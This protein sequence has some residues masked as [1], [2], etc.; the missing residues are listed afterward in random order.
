MKTTLKSKFIKYVMGGLFIT[1]LT[2]FIPNSSEALQTLRLLGAN[3]PSHVCHF[4]LLPRLTTVKRYGCT[5]YEG[6]KLE[7][8]QRVNR[9]FAEFERFNKNFELLTNKEIRSIDYPSIREAMDYDLMTE[10]KVPV[11]ID[12]IN[13]ILSFNVISHFH[14][15]HLNSF[16]LK[17]SNIRTQLEKIKERECVYST[18]KVGGNYRLFCDLNSERFAQRENFPDIDKR[19]FKEKEEFFKSNLRYTFLT[20]NVQQNY[21]TVEAHLTNMLVNYYESVSRIHR[22]GDMLTIDRPFSIK[23]LKEISDIKELITE[24]ERGDGYPL[25][26]ALNRA[27]YREKILAKI[28]EDPYCSLI[29][30]MNKHRINIKYPSRTLL[31]DEN[32]R[33]EEE[34]R[35]LKDRIEAMEKGIPLKGTYNGGNEGGFDVTWSDGRKWYSWDEKKNGSYY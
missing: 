33:K 9:S 11:V 3:L 32:D 2:S 18:N 29:V 6:F 25:N 27:I 20:P 24:N 34:D 23:Q 7:A 16:L 35:I 13:F 28:K 19:V 14:L 17:N 4:T 10:D 15:D 31:S 22:L 1:S 8:E 30:T 26:F 21:L 5:N 12:Y